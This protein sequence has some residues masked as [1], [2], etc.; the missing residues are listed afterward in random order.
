MTSAGIQYQAPSGI[1][2]H[3]PMQALF[4]PYTITIH[5]GDQYLWQRNLGQYLDT[6]A[7]LFDRAV[8]LCKVAGA[9]D[10]NYIRAGHPIYQY[11][12]KSPVEVVPPSG[13]W[14]SQAG[15]LWSLI[16]RAGLVCAF[17]PSYRGLLAAMLARLRRRK[18]SIYMGGNWDAIL[19]ARM[20]RALS[21]LLISAFRMASRWIVA[22]ALFTLTPGKALA[23][24]YGGE[25]HNVYL[26]P[27]AVQWGSEAFFDRQD[28]CQGNSV[29]VLYV[30][31]FRPQKGIEDLLE[32]F[33]QAV[34]QQP[35]LHLTMI[36]A[37]PADYEGSLRARVQKLGL[38]GRARFASYISDP[39][40]LQACYRQADLLVIPT[41]SEGFPRVACEAMS[42]GL[43]VI[44]TRIEGITSAIG[45]R[46]VTH[47][48]EPG[49]PEG[50]AQAILSLANDPSSRR[51][52]IRE[53]YKFA[54]GRM[55][56][57][58]S[59]RFFEKILRRA[60]GENVKSGKQ[61]E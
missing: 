46:P 19:P 51:R 49:S 13:R 38:E 24:L 17:I 44:A 55:D 36:G 25:A 50:I 12:M 1:Y 37:G 20:P 7:A 59:A 9:D 61:P 31:A 21:G 27:S 32:G 45:D 14:D 28:T 30:G 41:L 16:G 47:W 40:E 11:R 58:A 48:V 57:S 43:P 8:I 56:I 5:E 18:Y 52:L 4:V 29:E 6:L 15:Q 33:A 23:G 35:D 42:Q 34:R 53:G 2:D 22:R 10:P 3:Y 26:T 60:L 39:A 54:R